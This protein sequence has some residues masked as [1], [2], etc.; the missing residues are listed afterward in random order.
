MNSSEIAIGIMMPAYNAESTIHLAVNSILSQK[1][2]NWNLIIVNDGSSDKTKEIADEFASSDER[3]KVIHFKENKGR[4]FARNRALK[5]CL[6]YEYVAFL[7]ADDFFHPDKLSNQMEAFETNPNVGMVSCAMGSYDDKFVLRRVRGTKGVKP[8]K[9]SYDS[10][11]TLA[12]AANM[13]KSEIIG[14]IHFSETLKMAQDS[15]FMMRVGHNHEIMSIPN[16]LY[17][18][19]EYTS[20]SKKKILKSHYYNLVRFS[21]SISDFPL[22]SI[23]HLVISFAKFVLFIIRY[24]FLTQESVLNSRGINPNEHEVKEFNLIVNF[25]QKNKMSL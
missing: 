17:Y 20:V 9:Y 18:Y 14:E 5:E 12:R 15:D 2:T 3:I 11:F 7:D 19:S 24:R 21:K 8:I 6:K 23:N 16:V 1:Y 22:G 25:L 13:I 4:P 10:N